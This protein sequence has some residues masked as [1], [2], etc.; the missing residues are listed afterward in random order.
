MDDSGHL[1]HGGHESNPIGFALIF[2]FF[3]IVFELV[4]VEYCDR[5][6]IVESGSQNGIASFGNL[7]VF[8]YG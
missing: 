3:E 5:T 2:L 7:S 1:I 8:V 6:G 4:V